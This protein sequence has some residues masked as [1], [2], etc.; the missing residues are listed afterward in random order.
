M[1]L[2]GTLGMVEVMGY[3]CW[4][5]TTVPQLKTYAIYSEDP[6]LLREGRKV[7]I[8]AVKSSKETVC[9]VG[10][11]LDVVSWEDAK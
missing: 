2:T 5:I 6:N 4:Y 1:H 7:E 9:Q 8:E 10:I 11:L 3:P